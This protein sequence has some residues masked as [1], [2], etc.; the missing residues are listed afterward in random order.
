L[1]DWLIGD[2]LLVIGYWLII[3][4]SKLMSPIPNQPI[5]NQPIPNQ[6]IPNQP[7]NQS[8]INQSPINQSPI[9]QST[10]HQFPIPQS[11]LAL[12]LKYISCIAPL[13]I[14]FIYSHTFGYTAFLPSI[15]IYSLV[16]NLYSS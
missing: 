11:N 5:P 13:E 16:F 14:A 6:P 3:E 12:N 1:V 8:P 2:W 10:N 4:I 15:G 7:I 9:N